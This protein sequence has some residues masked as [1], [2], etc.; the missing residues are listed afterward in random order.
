MNTEGYT[1]DWLED[2]LSALHALR[3]EPFD[4]L[5]LDLKHA[6]ALDACAQQRMRHGSARAAC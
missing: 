3:S 1:L 6:E 5:L 4:L 2:G